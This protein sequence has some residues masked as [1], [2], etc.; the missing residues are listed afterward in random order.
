MTAGGQGVTWNGAAA[1]GARVA[2][3]IY[4]ARLVTPTGMQ[5][6]EFVRL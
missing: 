5:T 4:F 1:N 2:G 6:R 3:G